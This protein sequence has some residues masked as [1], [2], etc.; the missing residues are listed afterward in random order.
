MPQYNW[1]I[2][3]VFAIRDSDISDIYEGK[4]EAWG[5]FFCLGAWGHFAVNPKK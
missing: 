5:W 4:R 3:G 2:V 1:N